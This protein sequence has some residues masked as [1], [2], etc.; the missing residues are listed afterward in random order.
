[1]KKIT[2]YNHAHYGDLFVSRSFIKDICNTLPDNEYGYVHKYNS[3]YLFN[4]I[5][6]N[7]YKLDNNLNLT[8]DYVIDTWYA[9][10]NEKYY[11][12]SGCTIQTLYKLFED[13]Y[14]FIGIEIKNI[15]HYIPEID[16]N[17]YNLKREKRNKDTILICNNIPLSGQSSTEDMTDFI[18]KLAIAMPNKTFFITNDTLKP[19]NYKNIFYSKN[20]LKQNNL[21]E[22]SWLSTQCS[23]IIGRSSGPYTFSFTKPNLEEG[24]KYFEI[25]YTDPEVEFKNCNFGLH[26]LNY[27]NFYNINAKN[28]WDDIEIFL[29]KH[30]DNL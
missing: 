8:C 29:E 5:K 23:S 25:S 20:I 28:T 3:N 18:E 22:S 9:A 6:L 2:F 11:K 14:K 12:N 30:Y 27:N 17:F 24:L 10:N 19:L 15:K 1:M 21:I 7:E 13:A 4:D 16:F 26:H